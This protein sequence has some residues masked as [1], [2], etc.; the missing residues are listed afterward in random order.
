MEE[1]GYN[2]LSKFIAMPLMCILI[3]I[4][5]LHIHKSMVTCKYY[6]HSIFFQIILQKKND[7]AVIMFISEI[8][9]QNECYFVPY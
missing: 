5:F 1:N 2:F 8:N 9:Q 7:N 3:F 6:N 4:T